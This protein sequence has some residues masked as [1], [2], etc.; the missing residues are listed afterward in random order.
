QRRHIE[1]GIVEGWCLERKIEERREVGHLYMCIARLPL[2]GFRRDVRLII[3]LCPGSEIF[4]SKSVDFF[5]C[6]ITHK[7][8]SAV[9]RSVK[10]V[11]TLQGII[12][13]V[14]H[15]HNAFKKAYC[16]MRVS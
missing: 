16:G 9:F 3:S 2:R 10:P 13:L 6:H 5:R 12:V 11:E 4:F 14:G 8:D 7:K 1:G 15:V